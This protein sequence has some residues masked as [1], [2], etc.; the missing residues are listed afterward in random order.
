MNPALIKYL[1]LLEKSTELIASI[2]KNLEEIFSHVSD[3]HFSSIYLKE[4][5]DDLDRIK[6]IYLQLAEF[7]LQDDGYDAAQDQQSLSDFQKPIRATLTDVK[8]F[9]RD[10]INL[11]FDLDGLLEMGKVVRVGEW[12]QI[13]Y[14]VIKGGNLSESLENKNRTVMLS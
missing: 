3:H 9:K 8:K 1:A 4:L 11:R 7:S 13:F 10:L 14:Q 12:N 5:H 6:D 2:C